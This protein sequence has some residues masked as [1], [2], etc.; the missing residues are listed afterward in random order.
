M[1]GEGG[2]GSVE[3]LLI[4]EGFFPGFRWSIPSETKTGHS[5]KQQTKANHLFMARI[6]TLLERVPNF[7]GPSLSFCPVVHV[8]A[9]RSRGGRSVS[10]PEPKLA[11]V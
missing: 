5:M 2:G 1:V 9:L 6:L 11:S 4:L 10:K 3:G 8:L 7:D